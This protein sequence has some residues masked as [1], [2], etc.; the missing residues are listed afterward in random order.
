[1]IASLWSRFSGWIIGAL[2]VMAAVAG[3]YVRGRSAGKQVEQRK[4][5]ER[6]LDAAREHAEIIRETSNAQAE[7]DRLPDSDVRQRLRDKWQRD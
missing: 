4:A 7:I 6:D 5:T 2:G 1:M 3:I